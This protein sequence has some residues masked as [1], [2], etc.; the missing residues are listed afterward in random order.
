M[1]KHSILHVILANIAKLKDIFLH[2]VMVQITNKK[3]VDF[4]K[5]NPNISVDHVNLLLVDMMEK[6]VHDSMNASMV[7]HASAD[8]MIYCEK[9]QYS[10]KTKQGMS[11]HKRHCNK[12]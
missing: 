3:V 1:I 11:A 7:S 12:I 5:A 9:C 2:Y 6:M 4:Y 10:C 8:T